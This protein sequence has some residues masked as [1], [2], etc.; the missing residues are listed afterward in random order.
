MT[1]PT[2]PA[3]LLFPT[4]STR[5]INFALFASGRGSNAENLIQLAQEYPTRFEALVVITDQ[6][7]ARV[8]TRLNPYPVPVLWVPSPGSK[9]QHEI[10]I[11][12]ALSPF[13]PQWIFLVGYERILSSFFLNHFK[14]EASGIYRILNIHPSLLPQFP[15]KE[16]YQ[17]AFSAGVS[18]S[19]VTLHLVDE[20]VDTGRVLAQKT[21]PRYPEDTLE[22]FKARGL[23]LEHQLFREVLMGLSQHSFW[24]QKPL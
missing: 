24:F 13:N 3:P 18:V 22:S 14:E 1:E 4:P 16:G 17:Q 12:E 9:R 8:R 23:A 15:G 6:A 5:K 19:G 21:F 11:L 20:G 2:S 7:H 10:L